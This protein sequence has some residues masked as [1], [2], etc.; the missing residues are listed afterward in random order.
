M[1]MGG[2]G[3][4]G[5]RGDGGDG[6]EREKKGEKGNAKNVFACLLDKYL[7]VKIKI[8]IELGIMYSLL[9]DVCRKK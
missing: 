3:G 6:G 2:G 4:E 5:D 8:S 9:V 1:G 7:H